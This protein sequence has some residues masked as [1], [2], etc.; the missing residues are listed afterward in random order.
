[1]PITW[2]IRCISP[3]NGVLTIPTKQETIFSGKVSV[4][5]TKLLHFHLFEVRLNETI[6]KTLS[7]QR[8]YGKQL[9]SYPHG[10]QWNPNLQHARQ[11]HPLWHSQP[12]SKQ[13]PRPFGCSCCPVQLLNYERSKCNC[14]SPSL[15]TKCPNCSSKH[16]VPKVTSFQW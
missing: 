14:N 3:H 2:S 5:I 12:V 4:P 15:T 16:V 1:M 8:H 9:A 7:A 10:S 6:Y 13:N 11:P